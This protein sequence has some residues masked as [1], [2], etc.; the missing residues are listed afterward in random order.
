M[1]QE[2]L[3][4][5]LTARVAATPG[6]VVTISNGDIHYDSAIRR[7]REPTG[8][9]P[10]ETVRA[11]VLMHIVHDLGYRAANVQL[12]YR[13]RARAG[14]GQRDKYAD[15][16][17]SRRENGAESVYCLVECKTPDQYWAEREDA[18]ETQ[19]F[20]LN[21]FLE[22]NAVYLAYC[23][24]EPET[25]GGVSIEVASVSGVE[26]P[27]HRQW[28]EAGS[29][30][31]FDSIAARFGR[32][33]K[34]PWIRGG[35]KDLRRTADPK[36]LSSLRKELHDV[37]WGGGGQTDTDIF[38]LLTRLL[39]AKVHDEQT[40]KNGEPYRFQ[41]SPE[42]ELD[43]ILGRL[44]TLYREG[45]EK[46]L[47]LTSEQAS[48]RHIRHA[49]KGTDAQ[50][51]FAIERLEPY[52][53]TLLAV[54]EGQPDILGDFFEGVMR[55]GFKQTKGQ[56]FTHRNIADFLVRATG[57]AAESRR[58][59]REGQPPPKVLDPAAGSGTFLIAA[60]RGIHESLTRLQDQEGPTLSVAAQAVL[61]RILRGGA[62]RHAWAENHCF[63]LEL[64]NDLGLAAQ[65][66]MLLHADGASSIFAGPESGDALAPFPQYAAHSPT[67][68]STGTAQPYPKPVCE[69]FDFVLTNPPFSA[70][71][72][73]EDK[74]RH[75]RALD[76]AAR[77]QQSEDLFVDRWFQWLRPEGI[78]GA[79][80]PNSL[81]D[82]RKS[83]GRNHLLRHFTVLA[84][85]SLPADAFYP[86]TSTKTS[87]LIARKKT[88][89]AM[90]ADY[91][92]TPEKVLEHHDPILFAK[93]VYLGY[94]R[95]A[96]AEFSEERND[97]HAISDALE[98][99]TESEAVRAI[100]PKILLSGTSKPRL[101]ADYALNQAVVEDSVP[102]GEMLRIGPRDAATPEDPDYYYCE[103]GHIGRFGD[104]SPMRVTPADEEA[105][106]EIAR[107]LD[108]IRKKVAADKAMQVA[109]WSLLL[110]K[111]RTYLGKFAV[112]TGREPNVFFTTD[113]YPLAPGPELL[114]RCENDRGLAACA[115]L[116]S[117]KNRN[118]L[119][120]VF[121][122]LSRWGKAYPVLGED[123]LAR[124]VIPA[125]ILESATT[126]VRLDLAR[127]LRDSIRNQEE[128][129]EEIRYVIRETD[130]FV[131]GDATGPLPIAVPP[132][133]FGTEGEGGQQ[134]Y[135]P[136][137]TNRDD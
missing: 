89:A 88:R 80:V 119:L 3:F 38:N 98:I 18:F 84:I 34:T 69:Q 94:R 40:T 128:T 75:A 70:D 92:R 12:E 95:T 45:L 19:L 65:I 108:R 81:L 120:P 17:I 102:V 117:A 134:P 78:V 101:D 11:L 61:D 68:A 25:D 39:L 22:P 7:G 58:R 31:P 9:G 64:N 71:Y 109:D 114:S 110:P 60:M 104:I 57:L 73:P 63:G 52:D 47:H 77:S 87:L 8:R 85:V 127:R 6:S 41:A 83:E 13:V 1:T 2:E 106:P 112:V 14:R 15:I 50:I 66:N 49:G 79:V 99:L 62:R 26:Y 129:R 46:R 111:T 30:L 56:F 28:K 10:E 123:D 32:A 133:E 90:K 136:R 44:D 36:E 59:A 124:A 137:R 33:T 105:D 93:A 91:G 126:P 125:R 131:Y 24:V 35:D 100:S 116:L 29:P 37:L 55:T 67:L 5:A 118:E 76:I 16:V 96:K 122:S 86:H 135:R 4:G 74:S 132:E 82:G 21:L 72:S 43:E 54:Q 51:R 23:T 115:L 42:E 107:Q 20:G 113:L 48:K 103:I 97:L 53:F 130:A 121:S 27:G